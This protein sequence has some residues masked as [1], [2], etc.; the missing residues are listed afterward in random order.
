[1]STDQLAPTVRLANEIAVQFRH[2]AEEDAGREIAAHLRE[3]WDPRMRRD[4]I[5]RV[6]R[7]DAADLDPV[8]LRAVVLLTPGSR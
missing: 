2:R 8:A 7:G 6:E 4:L 3:F 1:M 5:D